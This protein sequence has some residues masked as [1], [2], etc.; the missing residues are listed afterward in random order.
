VLDY[1]FMGSDPSAADNVWLREA[2]EQ[3]VPIIYFFGEL[4][5]AT[6][7]AP[8]LAE[9]RYALR[10]VKQRLHQ[11]SFREGVLAAYEHRCVI[12]NR[13]HDHLLDAAHIVADAHE[14]LG[15]LVLASLHD[16]TLLEQSLKDIAGIRI[17]PP[18]REEDRPER[19]RLAARFQALGNN[20]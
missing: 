12:T 10:L 8:D 19:D 9:R 6:A 16:G 20:P 11:A 18:R 17:R 5:G 1:A 2:A 4:A 14:L 15:Q 7:T 3:Q 13:P